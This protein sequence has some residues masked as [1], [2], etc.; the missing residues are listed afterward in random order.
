MSEEK[1]RQGVDLVKEG[2]QLT[3]VGDMSGL[4][5]NKGGDP[6]YNKDSNV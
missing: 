3:W 6:F 2:L 1:C 5:P 4:T